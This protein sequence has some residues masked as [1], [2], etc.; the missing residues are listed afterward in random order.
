MKKI[1]VLLLFILISLFSFA[2]VISQNLFSSSNYPQGY[3]RNPLNI[4]I[5]LAANFG[6]LRSNHFHMGFDI[7]TNRRENLPVYA[8]AEGYVSRIKIEKSGF[9]RA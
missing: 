1:T 2:P 4:P 7:R 8:A 9:G 6:E 5:Q 3:F